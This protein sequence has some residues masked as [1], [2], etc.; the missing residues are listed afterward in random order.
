MFER[1]SL[2]WPIV[3]AIIMIVLI[4]GLAVGWILLNVFGA[5][6]G[7]GESSIYWVLLCVGSVMFGFI[8]AG[9]VMY[10]V[11]AI[12]QINLNRRQSNFI[13]AV[14]H[15]LKSPIAS[16]KLFLQTL[17]RRSVDEDQRREFYRS[18]LTDVDRLDQL[19]TQLLDV[20]SLQQNT[21]SPEPL[22]WNRIDR[23]V[24]H[25]RQSLA[26]QHH[27]E[28]ECIAVDAAPCEVW[29]RRVDVEVLLRN[30]ID[31]AIKY[32]G[33]PPAIDIRVRLDHAR[34]SV[35]VEVTDNGVGVPRHL[36]R[37]IFDRFYRV[38][39]E[40]ERTKPGTGLGLF[41]VRS[42]VKRLGGSI[43]IVETPNSAGTRF[44]LVLHQCRSVDSAPE[45]PVESHPSTLPE[46]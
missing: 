4:V 32:A 10:L 29:G 19:I 3:L 7:Q 34:D 6:S 23:M 25:F 43:R 21:E 11:L 30:L 35:K 18:M 40:L 9:V 16:L 38:G 42:I 24:E 8:L 39:N 37:K 12:Q 15:E 5:I 46:Q 22:C 17:G 31:N 33:S 26:N 44:E 2:T 28:L 1:K 45:P 20:A 36:R 14:T 41:L 13:D 27:V